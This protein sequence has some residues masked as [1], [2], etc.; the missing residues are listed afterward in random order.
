MCA[1]V[2]ALQTDLRET[3]DLSFR[4]FIA[5]FRRD[6]F[7][8]QE[9]EVSER[10]LREKV[11]AKRA[12][13][14]RKRKQLAE[15]K[16]EK[17]LQ[18]EEERQ[19]RERVASRE[20]ERKRAE[21]REERVRGC[22]P[23]R[24]PEEEEA[25]EGAREAEGEGRESTQPQEEGHNRGPRPVVGEGQDL[26]PAEERSV[27]AGRAGEERDRRKE[28]EDR[29]DV[30]GPRGEKSTASPP[31][32]GGA[33]SQG[34]HGQRTRVDPEAS[35]LHPERV[36]PQ[37]AHLEEQPPEGGGVEG[38]RKEKGGREIGWVTRRSQ[39]TLACGGYHFLR[40]LVGCTGSMY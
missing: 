2:C 24:V 5:I 7:T 21:E 11:A 22:S 9:V 19:R 8:N 34:S 20:K 13:D 37:G 18:K 4:V 25:R 30:P 28:E 33:P 39:I 40:I 6:E 10:E 14:E 15:W 32:H 35:Q 17:E 36:S 16:A 26:S 38:G 12:D 31:G 1:C 3:I 23:S 29:F 27:H